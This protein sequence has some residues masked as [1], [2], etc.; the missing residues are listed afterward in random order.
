MSTIPSK[1]LHRIGTLSS[2][3]DNLSEREIGYNT[4]DK[5]LYIKV[6]DQ[7]NH[8]VLVSSGC[9]YSPGANVQIDGSTISATD[10]NTHRPIQVNG[11]YIL[12]NNTNAL[13]LKNGTNISISASGGDVA[14]SA[15]SNVQKI[16]YGESSSSIVSSLLIDSDDPEGYVSVKCDNTSKG[17]LVA[18]PYKGLLDSG[19]NRGYGVGDST[20]PVY[21]DSNGMFQQVNSVGTP[22]RKM[23]ASVVNVTSQNPN[24]TLNIETG[25][26]YKCLVSSS[27]Q[28]ALATTSL[29]EDQYAIVEIYNDTTLQY[30][31]TII[32]SWFDET[33]AS[34]EDQYT[35]EDYNNETRYAYFVQCRK[36]EVDTGTYRTL[37]RVTPY[38]CR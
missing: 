21:V 37:C 4:E 9:K 5:L 27:G 31:P 12:G 2:L 28:I 26:F 38:P 13:N 36:V 23:V 30:S 35:F 32:V 24:I 20:H 1:Q 10:T 29:E 19:I 25:N 7:D 18:G 22:I 8:E 14:I 3:R 33:N 16:D 15:S 11:S 34:V 6:R 17:D